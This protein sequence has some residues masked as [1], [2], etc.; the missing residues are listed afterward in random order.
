MDTWQ[1]SR[2]LFPYF[3]IVNFNDHIINDR[4][5]NIV[6]RSLIVILVSHGNNRMIIITFKNKI[7]KE[8]IC[9]IFD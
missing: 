8:P 2:I 6:T 4:T 9:K 3:Y 1:Q 7:I 5:I